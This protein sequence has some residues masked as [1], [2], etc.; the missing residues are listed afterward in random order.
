MMSRYLR[1]ILFVVVGMIAALPS[2]AQS[3]PPVI[4]Y[5]DVQS[6]PNTGGEGNNGV[7]VSIFGENFGSSQ[8]G[9]TVTI[10]G[11]AVAAYKRWCSGCDATGQR[12]V[13]SVALGS[14][15]KSGPVVVNVGSQVS[16]CANHDDG[17][18]FAVR[19]G[20]IYYVS[21]SGSDTA[22]GS[23]AA[24][25]ATLTHADSTIRPGDTVYVM[26]GFSTGSACDGHGWHANFTLY[27]STGTAASPIA[28]IAYPGA[29]VTIGA[30]AS[31]SCSG[32]TTQ[33]TIRSS[34]HSIYYTL[35][36]LTLRNAI[37]CF[38][39]NQGDHFRIINNDCA[40]LDS[41]SVYAAV[42]G[43]NGGN[44]YLYF[45]GN[46]LH[47]IGGNA[48]LN[49]CIYWGTNTNHNWTAW[50][51]IGDG[52]TTCSTGF[53]VHSTAG[54]SNYDVHFHDNVV[55]NTRCKGAEL[56]HVDPSLGAVEVYNNIF[57]HN[58]TG[59]NPADSS[60][61][62]YDSLIFSAP[63][64]VSGSAS[65]NV[66]IYNNTFYDCGPYK[67]TSGGTWGCVYISN[68]TGQATM[69]RFTNN[70]F[71]PTLSEGVYF[72]SDTTTSTITGCAN[73]LYFQGGATPPF[74]SAGALTLNPL[75][76][77]VS[78][79]DFHL[80]AGSPAIGAGSA[81]PA[82]S[83]RD[84]DGNLRRNP[85]AIG[86]YELAGSSPIPPN[87]PTNLTITVQ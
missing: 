3:N 31:G 2:H 15:A 9:S 85:P 77:S 45:Y 48:K 21:P 70:I 76:A 54:T 13:I 69:Y 57:Y 28:Y 78:T 55:H 59:P 53:E 12:D 33:F 27:T 79:S 30:L 14:S 40:A 18:N 72:S 84:F 52:A 58:G 60:C 87:P 80:L 29:T 51:R 43:S 16:T 83:A 36:G 34:G 71:Y 73:N 10:G 32:D 50:N 11:G 20:N 1:F 66:D 7:I 39:D 26:N 46:N 4:F 62:S 8:G 23:F 25:W 86:A 44:G 37:A 49:S 81:S 19:T 64:D 5:T 65:G 35:S 42:G 24:P 6:G 67:N 47:D 38:S 17:C 41:H 63:S 74:C 68:A 82:M 75:L 61:G 56:S 22:A